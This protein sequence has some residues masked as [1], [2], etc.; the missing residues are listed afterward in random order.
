[1]AP[2]SLAAAVDEAS[3]RRERSAA[4]VPAIDLDGAD[5]TAKL[6]CE[7]MDEP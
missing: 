7:L 5:R 3:T 2:A 1:L 4:D 6:L